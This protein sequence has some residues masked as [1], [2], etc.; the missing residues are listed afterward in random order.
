M[1][2]GELFIN[3]HDAYTTWGISLEDGT[4]LSALMTPVPNK[5]YIENKSR[6][7]HGKRVIVN[8]SKKDE[9]V[10]SFAI[11]LVA[12]SESDFFTKYG[13]FCDTL[14]LGDLVIRTKYQPTVY[15]KCKYI[16]CTQF[17]QFMR[18]IAKFTLR[19]EEP[20]PSDRT[21]TT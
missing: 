20:N 2:V 18:G 5:P 16:S 11:T 9:R 19:I 10:I 6:L 1:P 4:A 8:N 7:E 15:Y 21:L 3:N 12:S 13:S 17:S 14:A